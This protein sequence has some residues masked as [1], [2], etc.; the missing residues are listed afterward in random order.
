MSEGATAAANFGVNDRYFRNTEVGDHKMLKM[1][2]LRKLMNSLKCFQ[3]LR[4]LN[5][6]LYP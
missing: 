1:V 6:S 5:W 4:L 2:G 3:K